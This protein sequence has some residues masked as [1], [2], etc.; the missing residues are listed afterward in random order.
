MID[1]RLFLLLQ[2]AAKPAADAGAPA[3]PQAAPPI[4][5]QIVPFVLLF[6]IFWFLMIRPQR[7][8]EKERQAML[9]AIKENDHVLTQGGIYGVVASVKDNEVVLKV[10]EK[11]GTRIRVTRQA[12]VSVEKVS[13]GEGARAEALP[14]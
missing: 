14:K 12:V 3:A 1:H 5:M 2:D 6:A 11:T 7:K 4:W 10:D 9:S 13:A 8:Q